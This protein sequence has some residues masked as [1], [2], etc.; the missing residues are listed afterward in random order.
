MSGDSSELDDD[1]DPHHSE[2]EPEETSNLER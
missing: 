2:E 1:I